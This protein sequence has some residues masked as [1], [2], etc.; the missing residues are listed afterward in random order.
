[1]KALTL[2]RPRLSLGPLLTRLV[3]LRA[4]RRRLAELDA[5][6]LADIGLTEDQARREALRPSWDAPEYWQ[7]RG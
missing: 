3:M 7:T 2:P 4:G 6:I 1:M 5:H